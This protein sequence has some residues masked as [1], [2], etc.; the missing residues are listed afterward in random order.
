M[1]FSSDCVLYG[2]YMSN[3]EQETILPKSFVQAQRDSEVT[4]LRFEDICEL[5]HDYEDIYIYTSF[6]GCSGFTVISCNLPIYAGICRT[7]R[8]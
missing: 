5:M 7:D 6:A 8:S 1:T 4:L 2:D 3:P